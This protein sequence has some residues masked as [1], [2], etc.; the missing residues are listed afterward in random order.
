M[1][2]DFFRNL[3]F[4]LITIAIIIGVIAVDKWLG[5]FCGFLLAL[6]IFIAFI[7]TT[8][9]IVGKTMDE[10]NKIRTEVE[11]KEENS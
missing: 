6:I 5:S 1:I 2:K 11:M 10:V 9:F 3:F 7:F 4:I 8:V